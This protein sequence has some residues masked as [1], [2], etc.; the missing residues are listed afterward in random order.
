MEYPFLCLGYYGLCL[1][2]FTINIRNTWKTTP[3][4]SCDATSY[5]S[6]E[7]DLTGSPI[8]SAINSEQFWG[9]C[10]SQTN[11]SSHHACFWNFLIDHLITNHGSPKLRWWVFFLSFPFLSFLQICMFQS[12]FDLC[13]WLFL[14]HLF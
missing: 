7:L 13:I 10:E 3:N 12:S 8:I 5:T 14:R 2:Y 4:E 6:H 1:W 9:F 11:L